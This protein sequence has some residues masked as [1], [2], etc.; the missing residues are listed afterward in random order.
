M[1]FKTTQ[2]AIKNN[3][4]KVVRVGYCGLQSL[5]NFEEP[6]A[7]TSNSNGWGCDVYVINNVAISTG[8]AP[9][10]NYEVDYKTCE[11]YEKLASDIYSD[12]NAPFEERV[13][14]TKALLLEFIEEVTK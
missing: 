5:L 2:K 6:I 12:Y 1:K 8:Y 10:G 11:K 3:Y 14:R 4:N 9:F 13:E 7:Y